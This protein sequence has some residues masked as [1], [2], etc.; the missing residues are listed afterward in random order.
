M[1]CPGSHHCMCDRVCWHADAFPFNEDVV[2]KNWFRC[3]WTMRLDWFTFAVSTGKLAKWKTIR[4]W[5]W[6]H[7]RTHARAALAH[8]MRLLLSSMSIV[9]QPYIRCVCMI[10][11]NAIVFHD[12]F[13]KRAQRPPLQSPFQRTTNKNRMCWCASP[14]N[15]SGPFLCVCGASEMKS[16]KTEWNPLESF[17]DDVTF[18]INF[19]D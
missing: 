17:A 3:T 2:I 10:T 19:K 16:K 9:W 15:D 7:N 13:E 8:I 4:T 1:F 11:T 5:T 18:S 12:F 14:H 6:T